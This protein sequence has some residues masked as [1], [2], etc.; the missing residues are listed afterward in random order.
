MLQTYI[1]IAA[2]AAA[3]PIVQAFL[4]L[5]AAAAVACGAI[6]LLRSVRSGGRQ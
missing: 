1:E 5:S 4:A 3:L 6:A 2:A